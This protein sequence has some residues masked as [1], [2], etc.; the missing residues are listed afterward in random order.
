MYGYITALRNTSANVFKLR[1][2]WNNI[3]HK[4]NY[5]CRMV[6]IY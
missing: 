3:V 6:M 5:E 1:F 2:D 4:T